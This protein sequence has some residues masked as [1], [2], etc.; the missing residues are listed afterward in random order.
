[1]PKLALSIH[2]CDVVVIAS[3]VKLR[4]K[5]SCPECLYNSIRRW[6]LSLILFT[7]ASRITRF[8]RIENRAGHINIYWTDC[9]SVTAYI[10][11]LIPHVAD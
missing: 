8:R 11:T 6:I 10:R 9:S 1:M 5:A 4:H 3:A 7:L 2:E